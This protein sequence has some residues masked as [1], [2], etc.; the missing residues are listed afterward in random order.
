MP[1]LVI[2]AVLLLLL[3]TF[4]LPKLIVVGLTLSTPWAVPV[5]VRLI[6]RVGFEPLLVTVTLPVGFPADCG[7]NTTLNDL[8][9]PAASVKGTVTPV[10]L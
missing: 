10:T 5:P 3:P 7:V 2:V 9:A 1:V 8:V 6:V 4:T